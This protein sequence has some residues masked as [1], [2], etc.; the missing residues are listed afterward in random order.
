M[1][2]SLGVPDMLLGADTMPVWLSNTYQ[3]IKVLIGFSII[4]F[5]HELGHFLAAKWVGIRVDR[6][7]VG[8]GP[9]LFG[10]R[11]GEG[12]TF[13][14]RPEYTAEELEQRS[15]SETDYCFKLLPVG[16][17]VKM[18][19]QDDVILN[20]E[21]GE[22]AL[23][24][25]PRAFTSRPVGHRMI[26][27]SA[28]VLFNLLFAVVLYIAVF[29]VGKQMLSPVIGTIH[30]DSPAQGKLFPGDRILEINGSEVDSFIDI[31]MATALSDGALRFKVE[32][33]GKS[34]P[35]EIV[36]EPVVNEK[37]ELRMINVDPVMTTELMVDGEEMGDLPGLKAGDTITKIDGK[38]VKDALDI[39]SIVRNSGGRLMKFTAERPLGD[40]T[41]GSETI[42][43]MQR[44]VLAVS[45]ADL[46]ADREGSDVDNRHILGLRRRR[47]VGRATPGLPADKAGFKPGDVIAAWGTVPNPTYEELTDSI[48]ENVNK[49]QRVLVERD[50]REIEL[51]VTPSRPFSLFSQK[52]AR[53]GLEFS[54][55]SEENRVIVADVVPNTPFAELNIPRGAE[56]L[57]IGAR[58]VRDWFDVTEALMAQAGQAVEVRYRSGTDE[59]TGT[60]HIPSSVMN[61]LHLPPTGVI[62][63]I[64][65]ESSVSLPDAEGRVR[66]L[67]LAGNSLA[68]RALF[69]SKIGQAVKVLCSD[70]LSAPRHEVDFS[71]RAD[72]VD[73]WQMRINYAY[74]LLAFAPK[75]ESVNAHGNPLRAI[76]MGSNYLF[77]QVW[78]V[79]R[80]LSKLADRSM[81]T[82]NVA[83]PVGIFSMAIDRAKLGLGELMF[84][85]AFLSV[86]LAVINFLPMPVMDGGLMVFLIIE[87]I[88]GKPLSLKTQMISTMVG[89]AAI[90]LIGLYVTVQDIG[91][92]FN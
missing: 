40:D 59:I 71:V 46:E 55:R 67:D 16:G 38:V 91:R 5:V 69:K 54:T 80:F 88:K 6:F 75:T 49:P 21:T 10:Y 89:L 37:G 50:G 44:A 60:V 4:I 83:G 43:C 7:S 57:A 51:T 63:A 3:F 14:N 9:R 82:K 2:T 84:F 77:T 8:F 70:S 47:V 18:L 85:M 86:N 64:D 27:V 1:L 25:D 62:W 90:I 45:Y 28:G 41:G 35:K 53:V 23:S 17:Y 74:E 52:K 87:K 76:K 79:Y 58:E 65:G 32:R 19:G 20:E 11:Q 73:P 68:A 39:I 92:F 56:L 42:E 72:N 12:F 29:M 36:V 34:L 30:P 33:D 24:D 26:V 78:Q 48:Q 61:E 22:V 66:T 81:G 13:G 15:Y 31:R